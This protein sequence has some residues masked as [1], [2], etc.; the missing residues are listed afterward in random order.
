MALTESKHTR[1]VQNVHSLTQLITRYLHHILPLFNIVCCNYNA[2][3]PAFLWSLEAVVEELL[4]LLF[5]PAISHADNFFP[6]KLPRCMWWCGQSS[7]TW[8]IGPTRVHI[9]NGISI[10]SAVFLQGS[11]LRQTNGLTDR[12]TH[13]ATESATIGCTYIVVGCRLIISCAILWWKMLLTSHT[14]SIKFIVSVYI[15]LR[16][17][18][19]PSYYL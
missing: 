19:M 13:H 5:Q 10:G 9:L 17:F 1:G 2:L 16:T 18:W 12:Q 8:F 7:N 4:I 15:R 11:R 3:G 6:S 14:I